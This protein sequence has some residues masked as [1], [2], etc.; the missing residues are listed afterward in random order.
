M[1]VLTLPISVSTTRYSPILR[2][3]KILLI[4][5]LFIDLFEDS[6][7][8]AFTFITVVAL[9]LVLPDVRD[10]SVDTS[11]V[12]IH[13]H[14]WLAVVWTPSVRHKPKFMR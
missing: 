4:Y 3:T 13:Q 6:G 2:V 11:T 14:V 5:S 8:F 10:E 12:L 1:L 7:I 9:I